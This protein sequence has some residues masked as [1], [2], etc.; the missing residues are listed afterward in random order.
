MTR[1]ILV[2]GVPA[3]GK[4]SVARGIGAR[5]GLPVLALD[6]VKEALFDELGNGG[7]DREHGRALGRA[8]IAAIWSLVA[9]FPSDAAVVV[10]A[11]FRLPPHDAVLRG[12]ARARIDRWVEVWCHAPAPVVMERYAN[13]VRHPGHPTGDYAAELGE[14]ARVARPMALAPVCDVETTDFAALDLDAVARWAAEQLG[15]PTPA[16]G[17][18]ARGG[19][20][21]P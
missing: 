2:N 12:L 5:L 1:A 18:T 19:T 6:A 17:R 20:A 4:S 13:R 10:D 14:L 8:S 9:D 11:W 7:G 16:T 3:S 21:A 15:L